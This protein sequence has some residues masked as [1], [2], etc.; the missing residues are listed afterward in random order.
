MANHGEPWRTIDDGRDC[1]LSVFLSFS[2]LFFFLFFSC[3]L[4]F[5]SLLWLCP[6]WLVDSFLLGR[7]PIAISQGACA[8]SLFLVS[9]K[10][11]KT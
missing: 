4:L 3:F 2:F 9:R 5:T 6:L 10:E 11:S 7:G 8:P 1:A